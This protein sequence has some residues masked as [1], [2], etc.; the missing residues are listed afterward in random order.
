MSSSTPLPFRTFNAV[1]ISGDATQGCLSKIEAAGDA[2][3]HIGSGPAAI[4]SNGTRHDDPGWWRF[5][6]GQSIDRALRYF[7]NDQ[8]DRDT[9]YAFAVNFGEG[10]TIIF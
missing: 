7:A 8:G 10:C 9:A 3:W 5:V 4:D 2:D 1:E 6:E